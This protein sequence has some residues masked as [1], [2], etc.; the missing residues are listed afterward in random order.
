M[1]LSL[2]ELVASYIRGIRRI[3]PHGAYSFGGWSIGGVLAY[4]TAQELLN[5]G[6]S[7]RDLVLIDSP[8]AN[9]GVEPLPTRFYD[10]CSETGIL[11]QI[12]AHGVSTANMIDP[13]EWLIPHFKATI[14]LLSGYHATPLQIPPVL[15]KGSTLMST[16]IGTAS[17]S[18]R[19]F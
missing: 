17:A 10:H 8:A 5:H 16:Q 15:V 4:R 12:G 13:P 1:T 19:R 11:G 18:C 6:F 7:V 2:E 9:G 3:Q 14:D